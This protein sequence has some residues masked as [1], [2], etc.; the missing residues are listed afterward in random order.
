VAYRTG[1]RHPLDRGAAGKAILAK[2]LAE[3]AGELETGA[4]GMAAPV[5][6]VDGLEA[7]VGVIALRPL[8]AMTVGPAVEAAAA[9]VARALS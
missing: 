2:A 7:S 3:T 9:T 5:L 4:Y 8:D 6:G 1:A